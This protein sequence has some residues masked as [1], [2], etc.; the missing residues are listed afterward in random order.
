MQKGGRGGGGCII[1]RYAPTMLSAL[2]REVQRLRNALYHIVIIQLVSGF[3]NS[4]CGFHL[5]AHI[6]CKLKATMR[7]FRL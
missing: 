5:K 7:D 4:I 3:M 6:L 2:R 1:A